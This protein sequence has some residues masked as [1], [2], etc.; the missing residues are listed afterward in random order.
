MNSAGGS[1]PLGRHRLGNHNRKRT[2]RLLHESARLLLLML[3]AVAGPACTAADDKVFR[4]LGAPMQPYEP[5]VFGYT[6]ATDDVGFIDFTLSVK[7]PLLPQLSDR[8]WGQQ[9]RV[10]VAFTGRFAFYYNTRDSSP[11]VVKRLNPK[12]FFE[13]VFADERSPPEVTYSG[14]VTPARAQEPRT[15][16]TFAYGHESN[17]QSVHTEAGYAQALASEKDPRFAI[18]YVSRGWDYLELNGRHVLSESTNHRWTV[19][20]SLKDFLANGIFQ[21]R[22]EEV[23]VWEKTTQGKPR[24]QVDGVMVR[25]KYETVRK[26]STLIGDSEFSVAYTTGYQD[27]GRYSTVRFEAGVQ[28]LEIPVVVW[29][30]KGYMSDLSRYYRLITSCGVGI[31]ISGF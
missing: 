4:V 3:S 12:L 8:V 18:D 6:R 22:P 31:A 24:K 27:F 28:A 14:S 23:N 16:A 5:N 19:N 7:Y 10:F 17:G 30:S 13:H 21:G 25:S 20:G 11:A 29:C 2:Q 1:P 9:N 26:D 15:A